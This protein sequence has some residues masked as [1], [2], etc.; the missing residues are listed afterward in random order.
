MSNWGNSFFPNR[1]L[2]QES[3]GALGPMSVVQIF[4]PETDIRAAMREIGVKARAAARELANAPAERKNRALS[5]AA[6]ILRERASEILA[7]NELDCADAQSQGLERGAD[8]PAYAQSGADRGDRPRARGGRRLARPG[9]AGA[10]ALHPSQWSHHRA[11]GDAARSRRRHLREPAQRD[12]GRRRAL[13]QE[14]QRGGAARRLGQFSLVRRHPR[15]PRRGLKRGRSAGGR[16][17]ARA[18]RGARGGRR[19]AEGPRRRAR[20]DRAAR[21]KKPGRSGSARGAR[22][23]VRPSRRGR[24]C[25]R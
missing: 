1:P 6:R 17:F 25:L 13:P 14:R 15:L 9:R 3:G 22:A 18:L 12:R 20:R 24:T 8:R 21:R 23:G 5:G 2:N 19:D 11:R 7:A 16:D 10:G 4:E